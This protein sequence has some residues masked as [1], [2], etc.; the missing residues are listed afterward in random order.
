M[1]RRAGVSVSP[2]DCCLPVVYVNIWRWDAYRTRC[3]CR[4]FTPV[5]TGWLFELQWCLRWCGSTV[6]LRQGG[7]DFPSRRF[8]CCTRIQKQKNFSRHIFLRKK[9]RVFT[10][11]A[12]CLRQNVRFVNFIR[13]TTTVCLPAYVVVEKC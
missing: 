6:A 13:T 4:S 8:T 2:L 1:P 10:S 5:L 7:R 3:C 9:Q 11:R 12:R